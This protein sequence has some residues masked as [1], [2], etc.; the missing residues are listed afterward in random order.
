MVSLEYYQNLVYNVKDNEL[1][2]RLTI[3]WSYKSAK[4]CLNSTFYSPKKIREVIYKINSK[5]VSKEKKIRGEKHQGKFTSVSEFFNTWKGR[6]D[7]HLTIQALKKKYN[8][9]RLGP[10]MSY[11]KFSNLREILEGDLTNKILNGIVS[12]NFEDFPCNCNTV[13]KV[14]N[15]CIYNSNCKLCDSIYIGKTH[16][17]LK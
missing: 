2:I 16:Q 4:A 9:K 7:I 8:H 11:H 15:I 12:Y 1:K 10:S 6:N 5:K 14:G 13:S 17:R 3:S